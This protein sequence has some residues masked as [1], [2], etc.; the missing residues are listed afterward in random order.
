VYAHLPPNG[1]YPYIFLKGWLVEQKGKVINWAFYVVYTTKEQM[2][3]A[4][5]LASTSLQ[6]TSEGNNVG[7]FFKHSLQITSSEDPSM[8]VLI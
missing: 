7:T 2:K 6:T 4:K 5:S 8:K 3:M 1:D